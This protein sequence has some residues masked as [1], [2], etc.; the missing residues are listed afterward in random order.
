MTDEE[1]IKNWLSSNKPVKD[2]TQPLNRD[3][4]KVDFSG[5]IHRTVTIRKAKLCANAELV[6]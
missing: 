6:S 5:N 2:E 4:I 3:T 1:L